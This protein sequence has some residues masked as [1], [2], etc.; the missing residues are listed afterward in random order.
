MPKQDFDLMMRGLRRFEDCNVI[1]NQHESRKAALQSQK[2]VAMVSPP[3]VQNP[4]QDYHVIKQANSEFAM[5]F[6]VT[7]D[8]PCQKPAGAPVATV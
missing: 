2:P 8:R 6:P 7:H 5:R 1:L 4:E 3:Q